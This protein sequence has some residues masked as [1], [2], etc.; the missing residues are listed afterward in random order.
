MSQTRKWGKLSISCPKN[1]FIW[2]PTFVNTVFA[3]ILPNQSILICPAH[4]WDFVW[5][6]VDL[7]YETSLFCL[8]VR[9]SY[10]RNELILSGEFEKLAPVFLCWHFK[11]KL[12]FIGA[13][14]LKQPYSINKFTR[15]Q[16]NILCITCIF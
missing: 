16:G 11:D 13:W 14:I 12:L 8:G 3:W 10:K 9:G 7:I 15:V 4:H 2:S 6:F 5:G 1:S